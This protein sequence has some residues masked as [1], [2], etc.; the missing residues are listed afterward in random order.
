M[1]GRRE[2]NP[3]SGCK[4]GATS[5][6]SLLG[7][8]EPCPLP[9]VLALPSLQE[10]FPAQQ[11]SHCCPTTGPVCPGARAWSR[12]APMH[13]HIASK[14]CAFLGGNCVIGEIFHIF[15]RSHSPNEK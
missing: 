1:C 4:G 9:S 6:S 2:V 5:S 15:I 10:G 14:E 3:C 12:V 7:P 8:A 13:M 11:D